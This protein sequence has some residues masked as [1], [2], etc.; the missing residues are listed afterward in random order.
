MSDNSRIDDFMNSSS[1]TSVIFRYLDLLAE[2]SVR[3]QAHCDELES[4]LASAVDELAQGKR[5]SNE[6]NIFLTSAKNDLEWSRQRCAELDR[7]LVGTQNEL[8]Q[9]QKRCDDLNRRLVATQNELMQSRS[10][11]SPEQSPKTDDS[12]RRVFRDVSNKSRRVCVNCGSTN[13]MFSDAG[14]KPRYCYDCK[15]YL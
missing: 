5:R 10:K 2:S 9:S 14:R 15:R 13:L 8:S 12:V 7:R 6:P 11:A 3:I 1:Q 4:R